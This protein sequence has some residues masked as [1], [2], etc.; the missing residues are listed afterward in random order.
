MTETKTKYP[1][2][3]Y[4]AAGVG[5]IVVEQLRKLSDKAAT[6]DTAKVREQVIAGTAVATAKAEEVFTTLVTRG[7]R[8]FASK[9]DVPPAPKPQEPEAAAKK[10]A[11]RKK[12]TAAA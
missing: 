7:E 2:A 9:G 3:V 4:A 12:T 6:I 10:A 5:D 1:K 8:A 11:P